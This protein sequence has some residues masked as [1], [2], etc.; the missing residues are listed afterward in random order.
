MI[1]SRCYHK[2][3]NILNLSL[4]KLPNMILTLSISDKIY[5]VQHYLKKHKFYSLKK[6]YFFLLNIT[7]IFPIILSVHLSLSLSLSLL[8]HLSCQLLPNYNIILTKS[9]TSSQ[10]KAKKKCITQHWKKT[11]AADFLIKT[12]TS[13][14]QY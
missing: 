13:Y 5:L 8:L 10:S 3:S 6:V 9:L 4:V 1:L 2:S 12:K 14:Y 11:A 7:I